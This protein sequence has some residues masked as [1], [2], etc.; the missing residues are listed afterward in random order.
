[1]K[2]NIAGVQH[3]RKQRLRGN[4][5]FN[6]L[7]ALLSS[8]LAWIPAPPPPYKKYDSNNT[9]YCFMVVYCG[10]TYAFQDPKFAKRRTQESLSWYKACMCVATDNYEKKEEEAGKKKRCN[11]SVVAYELFRELRSSSPT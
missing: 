4:L 7:L 10:H 11:L 1:M 2:R 8:N 6:A 5:R 9:Y 3:S